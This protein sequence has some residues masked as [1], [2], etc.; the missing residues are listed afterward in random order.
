MLLQPGFKV[1]VVHR[2]LFEKD[3]ER[4][5]IGEVD[6][7]EDGI[8][9]VRGYTWL[10]DLFAGTFFRKRD[11]RTKILSLASG[12]FLVYE[13]PADLDVESAGIRFEGE[14][15]VVLCDDKS[16]EMDLTEGRTYMPHRA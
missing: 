3:H 10:R 12:T 16:F 4:F 6:G 13:L 15:H 8:I 7:Y 2:R 5:F 9:R 11:E 1:L 14:D